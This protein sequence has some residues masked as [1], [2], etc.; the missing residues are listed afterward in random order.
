MCRKPLAKACSTATFS[1]PR[2]TENYR[3]NTKNWG[4]CYCR[5]NTSWV[6]SFT[7]TTLN[8]GLKIRVGELGVEV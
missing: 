7:V 2:L 5:G 8:A 3:L 1:I 6:E 4:F